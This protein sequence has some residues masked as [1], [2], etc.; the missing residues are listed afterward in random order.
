ML[1][2]ISLLIRLI[3]KNFAATNNRNFVY[4][5]KG[6]LRDLDE[7]NINYSHSVVDLFE[8]VATKF[9]QKSGSFDILA[10]VS[11]QH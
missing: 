11:S 10:Q 3:G 2:A 8:D 7:I 6:I 4:S 9:I 1:S 5:L